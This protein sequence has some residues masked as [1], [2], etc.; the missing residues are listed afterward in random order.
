MSRSSRKRWIL[1]VGVVVAVLVVAGVIA[2]HFAARSVEESIQEVLGPEG[3]AAQI[4][5]GL[6]TVEILDI[7]IKAPKG[8]PSDSTLRARRIVIVPDLRELLSDQVRITSIEVQGAYLS[9]LRPKEGG[10]LRVLP[11]IAERAKKNQSAGIERRGAVVNTVLLTDCVIEIY[12]ATVVGKAQKLRVDA[13]KGTVDDIRLLELT[14]RTRVDLEGV[15]RGINR[16]GTIAVRGWVEVANKDAELHTQVRNVDLALFEPYVITKIKS[17]I[18]SGSFNLDLRSRVKKNFV[19]A[20]GTLTVVAIKL[21]PSEN[22]LGAIAAVPRDVVIGALENEQNEITIPFKVEGDLDDPAFSLT[23]EG[24]LQTAV[25]V[26]KAFGASFE[27]LVR[28]FLII[29]NGFAGAFRALVP[30]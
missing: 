17:G 24:T 28:A 10:G 9:A 25:A 26:A 2:M 7:R 16:H 3:E 5:V 21:K 11:S 23:G 6:T 15:S 13:V 18:D 19:T 27:G 1:V 4:K 22:P 14:N 30:G 20:S 8:W 12:D 29:V